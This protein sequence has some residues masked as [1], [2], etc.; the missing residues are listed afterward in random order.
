MENASTNV[1]L[2][3]TVTTVTAQAMLFYEVRG[4]Q[5]LIPMSRSIATVSDL[6]E[7]WLVGRGGYPSVRSMKSDPHFFM[8]QAGRQFY[9]RRDRIVSTVE[10]LEREIV[11]SGR[12]ICRFLDEVMDRRGRSLNKLVD[13][14]D[15]G[16]SM[17]NSNW[18]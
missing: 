10:R 16:K 1:S 4:T 18:T 13:Y 15:N 7:E 12:T 2:G 5:K 9:S 8:D 11:A 6:V 17:L 14:L 3:S